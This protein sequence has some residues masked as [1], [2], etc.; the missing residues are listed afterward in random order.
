MDLQ[1]RRSHSRN[2]IRN[3]NRSMRIA[4]SIEQ[5]RIKVKAH[6]LNFIDKLAF[7]IALEVVE[8]DLG[9]ASFESFEI[10]LEGFT[11]VDFRFS[12]PQKVEVGTVDD[13]N[14]QGLDRLIG[15]SKV[16][17]Y[18]LAF[19]RL[20]PFLYPEKIGQRKLQIGGTH[21]VNPVLRLRIGKIIGKSD[22][23]GNCTF[24]KKLGNPSPGSDAIHQAFGIVTRLPVS[25]QFCRV[26]SRK[27]PGYIHHIG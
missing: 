27:L 14:F 1:D 4:S 6:F 16:K 8:L 17:E 26:R 7:Y 19:Q 23:S 9:K 18:F 25:R 22:L 10:I 3:G 5:N 13:L 15:V 2:S 11:S 12:F 20:L 21:V 24:P